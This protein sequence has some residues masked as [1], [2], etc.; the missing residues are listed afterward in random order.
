[1]DNIDDDEFKKLLNKY[2]LKFKIVDILNTLFYKFCQSLEYLITSAGNT[3]T[4]SSDLASD[5]A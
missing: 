3:E 2:V 5:L 4:P 1:M